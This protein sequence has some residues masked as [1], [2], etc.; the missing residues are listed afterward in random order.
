MRD[1][2]N[3]RPRIPGPK[4]CGQ[5]SVG[6][7]PTNQ[8]LSRRIEIVAK[9][10]NKGATPSEIHRVCQQQFG[11]DWRTA[12]RYVH[13]AKAYL[14]RVV[15]MDP[16]AAKALGMNVLLGVIRDGEPSAR[17]AAERRWSEIWGYNAPTRVDHSVTVEARPLKDV[18]TDKLIELVQAE[19]DPVSLPPG[20]LLKLANGNGDSANGD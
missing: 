16:K 11:V 4:E 13:R 1:N 7:K 17:V 8:E 20:E 6:I 2:N 9:L 14:Q 12:N 19:M 18:P 15:D 5:K 3:G 10:F